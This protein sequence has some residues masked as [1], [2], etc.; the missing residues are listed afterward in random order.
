MKKLLALLVAVA[1]GITV[2]TP[3]AS[4][5]SPDPN[6]PLPWIDPSVHPNGD[7]GGWNDP[8]ATQAVVIEDLAYLKFWFFTLRFHYLISLFNIGESTVL[9]NEKSGYPGS[10]KDRRTSPQG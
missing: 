5:I 10:T 6:K 1:L 4:A 7:E 8:H 3:P 9:D 2:L